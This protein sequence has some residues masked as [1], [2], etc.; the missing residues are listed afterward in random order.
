MPGTYPSHAYS[1]RLASLGLIVMLGLVWIVVGGESA[2]AGAVACGETITADTTLESDLVDCPNNGILIGADDITLDLNGH[3][4]DGD[5][6][7]VDPCP[8]NEACDVGVLNDGHNGVTITGGTV[9]EF[10]FGAFVFSARRNILSR[11]TTFEHVFGG[12]TLVQVVRSSVRGSTASR[13]AGPDSGVGIT[14]IESN[15]NRI[16]GNAFFDNREL[17]IHLILSDHNY[18]AKNRVRDNPEDGIILQ[19]DGNKIVD[20]RVVRNSIGVTIFQNPKRAVGNVVARNHVRRGP[21]GGI[22]VDSVPERTVI[23]RNHVFRTGRHGILIGN[24][25]TMVTRNEARYN[26]D[27]GIKAVK[28]VIDG[29]GNRASGNGDRRQCVN[30]SCH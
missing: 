24:S 23:K 6:A 29:G 7:P 11:L 3:M 19:G 10:A 4:I 2:L 17:G 5:D 13:N 28:G 9:K 8:K 18:V 16:V 26:N 25:T 1:A 30:I 22:Y 21:R 20:N 15:N 12:F 14:L 27:L